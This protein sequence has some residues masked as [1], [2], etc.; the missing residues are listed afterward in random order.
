MKKGTL[1]LIGISFAWFCNHY[2]APNA[3]AQFFEICQTGSVEELA[4]NI[5][6]HS[7]HTFR[8]R[9][10]FD[11]VRYFQSTNLPA[12]LETTGLNDVVGFLDE[13]SSL[14]GPN[15]PRKAAVLFYA[16]NKGR[17]CT[18]LMPQ[19]RSKIRSHVDW[20]E[21]ELFRS[22]RPK[23]LNAFRAS[24][25]VNNR[26]PI[27]RG[28][29][30]VTENIP[31]PEIDMNGALAEAGNLLLPQT[32][33][34]GLVEDGIETLVVVPVSAI[35]T[36]PFAALPFKDGQLV[37]YMSIVVAPDFL[38]FQKKPVEAQHN[39]Y[40]PVI[41]GDPE[42]WHDPQWDF[43]RLP[44]ARAEAEGVAKALQS[45]ALIGGEAKKENINSSL[46]NP[47]GTGLIY[48]A[49]HGIA[50]KNNPLDGSFLLLSDGRWAAREMKDAPI[51]ESRPLVVMSACQ[52][53]LGKDFDVGTIGM[54]RA[55]LYAGASSVVMSL[56][57][58]D[59]AATRLLMTTFIRH[60]ATKPP[61]KALQEAMNET[62]HKYPNDPALWAGFS[63]FGSPEL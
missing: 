30:V 32:I 47:S 55:W 12:G 9:Y 34:Q 45:V 62:R 21:E 10:K 48:L 33:L 51:K 15:M 6:A 43:P 56:W 39:F 16:Y 29:G 63:V 13:L 5:E 54:A 49:T 26:L 25:K 53:G 19:S 27:Q 20:V 23:I 3:H 52:T 35:G 50:D 46:R 31:T 37:D 57:N 2:E 4:A 41:V 28:V 38:A 61:D 17:L 36:I 59:D 44:G 8:L 11:H 40:N 22:M 7:E 42:G 58:V 14:S 24:G 18:W 60:A 1:L